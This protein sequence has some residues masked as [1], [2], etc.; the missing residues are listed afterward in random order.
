MRAALALSIVFGVAVALSVTPAGAGDVRGN[1]T[2]G[3]ISWSCEN[4]AIALELAGEHC[5]WHR[6]FARI[7]SV[8][9]RY[10]G[11][12]AFNCLWNPEQARFAL[13]P[14]GT[15]RYCPTAH[16]R[17]WPRVKFFYPETSE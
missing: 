12:I 5:A 13:P 7:S 14:A 6:K 15:N 1:D 10:G 2:G 9:R 11:Y 16:G 3:I 4:E 17:L 8:D